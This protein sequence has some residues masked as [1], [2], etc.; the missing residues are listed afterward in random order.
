MATRLKVTFTWA[1]AEAAKAGCTFTRRN[2]EYRVNLRGAD[3]ATAYYTDDIEDAVVTAQAMRR[4]Q[5]AAFQAHLA[6][7]IGR[8]VKH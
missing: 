5:S 3:E 2:G 8:M 6:A 1:K 7:A 4:A